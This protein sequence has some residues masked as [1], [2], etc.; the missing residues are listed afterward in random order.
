M[1]QDFRSSI[2]Y[3]KGHFISNTLR[4]KLHCKHVDKLSMVKFLYVPGKYL[5]L[6]LSN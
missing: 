4:A 3:I 2:A 5:K 6:F 1:L